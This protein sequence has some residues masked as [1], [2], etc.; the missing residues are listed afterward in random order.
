MANTQ[1]SFTYNG[2]NSYT[3]L[4]LK[5]TGSSSSWGMP[6][7]DVAQYEIPGRSGLVLVDNNRWKERIITYRVLAQA[8]TQDELR[9]IIDKIRFC[10]TSNFG[11]YKELK[12]TISPKASVRSSMD[13]DRY[14]DMRMY[15]LATFIGPIDWETTLM[16]RGTCE[17]SFIALPYNF[18][19]LPT[20][21]SWLRY[22]DL[23]MY[24]GGDMNTM[25]S[26]LPKYTI[27]FY[28][29]NETRIE[30]YKP[31]GDGD[32]YLYTFNKNVMGG[33]D[34]DYSQAVGVTHIHFTK[35][36]PEISEI[37][38]DTLEKEVTASSIKNGTVFSLNAF[39]DLT[40]WAIWPEFTYQDIK[41]ENYYIQYVYVKQVAADETTGVIPLVKIT[42]DFRAYTI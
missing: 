25:A 42:T 14:Y 35:D 24:S 1:N 8:D 40:N 6:E 27:Q 3:D 38:V 22:N 13:N 33:E 7:R 28:S 41:D 32:I 23:K 20:A 34:I 15:R 12:D 18:V 5:I 39:T 4:G 10:L 30:N 31:S 37:V 21:E 29:D 9:K 19:V 2:I 11:D 26:A 36:A 17:L 16:K